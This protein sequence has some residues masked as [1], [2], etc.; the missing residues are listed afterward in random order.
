MLQKNK[1]SIAEKTA[2]HHG[3]VQHLFLSPEFV[4]YARGPMW[5]LVVGAI[6]IAIIV[7]GILAHTTTLV[8][9]F[10]LFGAIYWLLHN[11]EARL[12]ETSITRYGVKYG[13][14]FFSFD[15]IS[16]FWII[17]KPPFVADLKLHLKHKLHPVLTIHIFGQD[18]FALRELLSP[19]VK[20]A[21]R[22][23]TMMDLFAR[24]LRL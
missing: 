23:E 7:L 10:F 24:A 9:A 13:D 11:R 15:E 1:I 6:S 16:E 12:I 8:I 20:D 21:K 4:D 19:H 2:H 14:E 5:Y 17:H 22:E 3:K 18:P